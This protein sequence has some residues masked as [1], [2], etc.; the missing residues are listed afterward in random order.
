MAL[1][2]FRRAEAFPLPQVS[3]S[4]G[5]RTPANRKQQ[6]KRN[7]GSMT[8]STW[9]LH[10]AEV[11]YDQAIAECFE[12]LLAFFMQGDRATAPGAHRR[13]RSTGMPASSTW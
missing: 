12:P 10:G 9:W 5:T 13:T 11:E 4:V 8:L 7:G 1:E 2:E 3:S 6:P